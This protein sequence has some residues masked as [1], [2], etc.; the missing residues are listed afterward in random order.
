[1]NYETMTTAKAN[2][3]TAAACDQATAAAHRTAAQAH[4]SLAFANELSQMARGRHI[5]QAVKHDE[6]ADYY[7]RSEE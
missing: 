1:M 4:A 5:E 3:L 7:E 6:L 2:L